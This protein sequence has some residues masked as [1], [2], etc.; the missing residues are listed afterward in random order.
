MYKIIENKKRWL[1]LSGILV[2][3]SI[4]MLVSFG[5]KFGVDF[6]GGSLL[7]VRYSD[8]RPEL[9]LIKQSLN[10]LEIDDL[11]IKPVGEKEL[12][13]KFK[14]IDEE[15]HAK[16]L[17]RLNNSESDNN[18]E[19]EA[20]DGNVE[21]ELTKMNVTELRFD[22]VGPSIGS[23]L[24]S[25]SISAIIWV[26]IAIVLFIAWAFRKVSKDISS[27]KY[28]I[29]S[30]VTL[31]HD[32]IILCGVFS[33]LGVLT[34]VEIGVEFVAAILTI[35][36]YSVNDTI[37]VF[38]RLRENLPKSKE[39]FSNT[40]N[41]SV[42]QTVIR[43]INTSLTTLLVLTSIYIWGGETIKNFVLALMVGVAIGTY[44]SIFLASPLLVV[45]EKM[46]KK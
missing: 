36:G 10:E 34:G 40:V 29:V 23:E 46:S 15:T 44:S 21:I 16:I 32:V 8:E 45:W 7:E 24:K 42:N 27:W 4:F 35:L 19:I 6:T 39:T 26:I 18:T 31:F 37:V 41:I 30:I 3:A 13:L 2:G 14:D 28:G 38:D 5:L 17:T 33:L 11:T 20:T 25:K 43:S 12:I 1:V 22:S 9:D